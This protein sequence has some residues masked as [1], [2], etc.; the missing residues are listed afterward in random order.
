IEK[1][2]R[3]VV[4]IRIAL[5]LADNSAPG[6]ARAYDQ[7]ALLRSIALDAFRV[8]A[9]RKARATGGEDR[10]RHVQQQDGTWI[11][12][13]PS[14]ELDNDHEQRAAGERCLADVQQVAHSHIS[15]PAAQQAEAV[16]EKDLESQNYADRLP[17]EEAFRAAHAEVEAERKGAIVRRRKNE[18]FGNQDQQRA[19]R[20]KPTGARSKGKNARAL[21]AG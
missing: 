6:V 16:E 17:E 7:S 11:S 4:K 10:Q 19:V 21:R 18:D 1:A 20:D 14:D 5:Q 9:N 15:P 12:R 13:G 2:D 8:G 3:F